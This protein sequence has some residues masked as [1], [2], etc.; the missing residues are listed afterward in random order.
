MTVWE[1][2][3]LLRKSSSLYANPNNTLGYGIPDF[4]KA[5]Q[6]VLGNTDYTKTEHSFVVFPNPVNDNFFIRNLSDNAPFQYQIFDASGRRVYQSTLIKTW[7]EE[8]QS[9]KALPSGNY[10]LMI[11]TGSKVQTIQLQKL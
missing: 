3:E 6:I 7:Q 8:C 1:L 10:S 5:H 2:R 4:C 11:V 9:M